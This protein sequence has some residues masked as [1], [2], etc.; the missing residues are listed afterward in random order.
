[1]EKANF[2]MKMS[3]VLANAVNEPGKIMAAYNAFYGY[4]FGN[5]LLAFMQCI[6]RDIPLGPIATYKAWS[7]KGRQV[8]KGQKAISLCM[9]VSCKVKD[10][11]KKTGEEKEKGFTRFV[12]RNRWFVLA[13]TEGPEMEMPKVPAWDEATA[14]AALK[15]ERVSF[16][17]PNGN[18]QGYATTERKVAVNPLAQLP[19]KTLFHELGHIMLGHTDVTAHDFGELPRDIKEVEAESVALLCLA[20]LNLP[21]Q[22]YCRGYIQSW[23]KG[24]EIPEKSAQKIMHAADVILKAGRGDLNKDG[25][26]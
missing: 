11:D 4:S 8:T 7:E 13:Q 22:E 19:L 24:Q 2:E 1:M 23:L 6:A 25:A 26:A 20:A 16:E 3:T 14:L 15:I 12:F 18:V 21:G 17:H 5:Q 10:T 9:P